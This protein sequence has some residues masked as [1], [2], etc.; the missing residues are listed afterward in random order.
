MAKYPKR[1]GMGGEWANKAELKEKGVTRAKIT[2]ETNPIPSQLYKNDDG[3]P[4]I[5]D[6]CKVLFEG[7][8]SSLNVTLNRATLDGL[9]DAFGE[10]SKDW[11]GHYL[12]VEI[13]KLPGKKFPLYLIPEGYQRME[14]DNGYAVIVKKGEKKEAGP[15]VINL[16]EEPGQ[17]ENLPF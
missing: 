3:T 12:S 1:V 9:S 15:E 5:Q 13:D 11:Q 4:Q 17:E 2:S 8:K 14:D 6:V 16:D 10:D 7:E